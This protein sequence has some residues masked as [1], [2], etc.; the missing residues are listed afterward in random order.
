MKKVLGY[1][2]VDDR[3]KG[4]IEIRDVSSK[5]IYVLTNEDGEILSKRQN[6]TEITFGSIDHVVVNNR[7]K[8]Y[9]V[10]GNISDIVGDMDDVIASGSIEVSD[11]S[12][13][14]VPSIGDNYEVEIDRSR[15][16]K[17]Y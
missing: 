10:R 16:N 14:Y 12:S 1:G 15:L 9:E 2:K 4:I 7:Y 11:V 17:M 8:L 6:A 3:G 5:Y 13:I